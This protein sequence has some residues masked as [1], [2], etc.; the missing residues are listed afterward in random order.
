MSEDSEMPCHWRKMSWN[1]RHNIPSC[2]H[3]GSDAET[4]HGRF[5]PESEARELFDMKQ[6]LAKLEEAAR[7]VVELYDDDD[8]ELH[9]QRRHWDTFQL[10]ISSLRAALKEGEK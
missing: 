1:Q 6:R 5:I 2:G 3:N 9:M 7:K 10:I 8:F 4:K